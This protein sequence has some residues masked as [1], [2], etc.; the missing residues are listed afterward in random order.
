MNLIRYNPWGFVGQLGRETDR[1]FSQ[2]RLA[3]DEDENA[4]FND[5]VPA[6]DIKE[7]EDRYLLHAD[8]PGVAAED[9]DITMDKGVLTLQGKRE[10]Q[11]AE[12]RDG[13]RRVERVSGKFYRRFNLPDTADST[14]ISADYRNGVLEV[15]IPKQ[16]E[17]KPQR[18]QVKI[19]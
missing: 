5:W 14:A 16:A 4:V 8:V 9:L 2:Q 3:A 10:T 15:S 12:D 18:I 7:E 1:L 19:N 17:A 13:L 6:I 11:T